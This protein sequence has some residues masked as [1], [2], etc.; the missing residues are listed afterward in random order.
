MGQEKLVIWGTSGHA[1][2]VT[3]IIQLQGKYKIA[4][5]LDD[6]NKELHGK[7][8]KNYP[9]LGGKEKLDFLKKLNIKYLIFGFGDCNARLSLSRIVRSKGFSLCTAIHPGSIVASDVSIGQGTVITAGAVV[10]PG[11]IIGENVI[12]NTCASVDHDCVVHDGAH[13]SPGVN[14][15]GNVTVGRGT[16]IGIGATIKEKIL[17]GSHSIIGAGSVVIDNIPDG[18][19]AYG[20]PAKVIRKIKPDDT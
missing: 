7:K 19:V 1:L 12:I 2:V 20:I 4:G 13:I 16:W 17:I 14:L 10:N 5:F 8:L 3:D 6:I 18:V 9:I 11:S 15:G